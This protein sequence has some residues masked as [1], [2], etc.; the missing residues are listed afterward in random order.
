MELSTCKGKGKGTKI[1]FISQTSWN[2]H[3]AP[4]LDGAIGRM[5]KVFGGRRAEILRDRGLHVAK[6][7]T[8][9]EYAKTQEFCG[10]KDLF[11]KWGQENASNSGY[12]LC[13]GFHGE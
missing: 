6:S 5:K 10:R 11:L 2:S 12:A 8:F 3:V 4:A 1:A 13:V 7:A 9:K